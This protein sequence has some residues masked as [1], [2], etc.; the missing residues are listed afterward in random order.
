MKIYHTE[1]RWMSRGRVLRRVYDLKTEISIFLSEVNENF[2]FFDDTEWMQDFAFCVDITAHLN[3]LSTILQGK[4][5][6]VDFP[7]QRL[8]TFEDQMKT[9]ERQLSVGNFLN[10]PTL[11]REHTHDGHKYAYEVYLLRLAFSA[12]FSDFRKNQGFLN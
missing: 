5:K 1:I 9:W 3:D 10:F 6:L 2:Y 7:F 11:A 12:R 8:L 4:G